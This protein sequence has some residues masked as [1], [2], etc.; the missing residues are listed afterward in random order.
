MAFHF[1]YSRRIPIIP[2]LLYWNI[3]ARSMSL[4][5]RVG[6]VSHTRSTSGRRTTSVA[7]PG[8]GSLRSVSTAAGRHRGQTD[9]ERE[10][11]ATR[12]ELRR[13]IAARRAS[14]R[15]RRNGS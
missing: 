4:T 2:G 5:T 13:R 8:R 7:L 12:E 11:Q 3:N 15:R 14:I 10:E 1:R 6:P 9:Q